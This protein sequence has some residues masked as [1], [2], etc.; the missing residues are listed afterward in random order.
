MNA[1]IRQPLSTKI[2]NKKSAHSALANNL[3]ISA[4]RQMKQKYYNELFENCLE[5]M[6]HLI[7][8]VKF[9]MTVYVCVCVSVCLF[10]FCAACVRECSFCAFGSFLYCCCRCCCCKLCWENWNAQ[11]IAPA[12]QLTHLL[13][14]RY[15]YALQHALRLC[16]WIDMG[17]L[18]GHAY[19]QCELE[20]DSRKF[21]FRCKNEQN[22]FA[23]RNTQQQCNTVA[24]AATT[25]A[26]SV[27]ALFSLHYWM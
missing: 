8:C 3:F 27:C 24:T 26:A 10:A 2:H 22:T 20:K 6:F 9:A 25:A 15:L 18:N 12:M 4:K 23:Q 17:V 5:K 13:N 21:I 14:V 19:S 11:T 1:N 7:L 16:E